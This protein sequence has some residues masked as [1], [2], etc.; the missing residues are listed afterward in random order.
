MQVY[1]RTWAFNILWMA[2]YYGLIAQD[3]TDDPNS[4]IDLL[5]GFLLPFTFLLWIMCQ[6]N[7]LNRRN[8]IFTIFTD[9][10]KQRK[11]RLKETLPHALKR[12]EVFYRATRVSEILI[13][14]VLGVSMAA[15]VW[16]WVSGQQTHGGLIPIAARVLAFAIAVLS[17]RYVKEANIAAGE[18]LQEEIDAAA[19]VKA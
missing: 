8:K 13:F 15:G 5:R 10:E 14:V 1:K 3:V 9:F 4:V 2:T 18:A 12:G 11:E 16:P 17:W 19:Q 6:R 7:A